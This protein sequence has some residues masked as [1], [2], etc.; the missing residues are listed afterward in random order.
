MEAVWRGMLSLMRRLRCGQVLPVKLGLACMALSALAGCGG[1]TS[2]RQDP[3]SVRGSSYAAPLPEA[4]SIQEAYKPASSD[5]P[6]NPQV[7]YHVPPAF[8]FEDRPLSDNLSGSIEM[9]DFEAAVIR[10]GYWPLLEGEKNYTVLA[11]PNGPFE[12]FKHEVKP[13]LMRPTG[14]SYLRGFIG[15]M[16]LVGHWDMPTIQRKAAKKGGSVQVPTLAGPG[17]DVILKPTVFGSVEVIGKDGTVTLTG[18]GYPQANG[19]LYMAD[20][21]LPY[22]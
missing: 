7:K 9:A 4:K 16:I 13:D 6:P 1:G 20:S 15:Q 8:S 22:Q 14:R 12:A 11:V 10:A 21:I 18:G 2:N 5:E 17:H 3:L 19:V